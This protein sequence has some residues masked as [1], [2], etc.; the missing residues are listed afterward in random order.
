VFLLSIR[1]SVRTESTNATPKL[2]N[3]G[4]KVDVDVLGVIERDFQFILCSRL[5]MCSN[6]EFESSNR[7]TRSMAS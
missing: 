6:F 4:D 7:Q 3:H 5:R 2:S 1:P